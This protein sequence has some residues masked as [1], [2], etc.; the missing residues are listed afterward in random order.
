MPLAFAKS[1]IDRSVVAQS[2]TSPRDCGGMNYRDAGGKVFREAL[3]Q[4]RAG[5]SFQVAPLIDGRM[6]ENGREFFRR[7]YIASHLDDGVICFV[8]KVWPE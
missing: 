2:P 1:M 4:P 8:V 3:E 5:R 6:M 7:I